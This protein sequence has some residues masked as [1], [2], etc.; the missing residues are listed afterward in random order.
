VNDECPTCDR[1]CCD[2]D[3]NGDCVVDPLDQGYILARFGADV[4]VEG[5]N[6][7]VNCDG[8]IDPLDAGYNLARFGTCDPPPECNTSC[9]AKGDLCS[10]TTLDPLGVGDSITFT[11][12]TTNANVEDCAALGAEATWHSVVT[13]ATCGDFTMAYCGTQ[14][15]LN[16]FYIVVDDNCPCDGTWTFASTWDFSSCGDDTDGDGFTNPISHYFGLP[17]GTW[18]LPVYTDAANVGPYTLTVTC[19]P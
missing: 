17:A 6:A 11:G 18:Y 5:C 8:V 15:N 1:W 16:T 2:G 4:C 9:P 12:D 14:P 13:S 19:N 3:A 10:D 7:D